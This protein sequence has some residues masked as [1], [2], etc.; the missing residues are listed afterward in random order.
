MD[1]M[2]LIQAQTYGAASRI[3][4]ATSSLAPGMG[5]LSAG[6][7]PGIIVP[8]QQ[9]TD[10]GAASMHS[11]GRLGLMILGIGVLALVAFNVGTRAYQA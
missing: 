1:L 5:G 10:D 7:A 6:M 11:T 9:N 2:S 3:G 4:A 8:L